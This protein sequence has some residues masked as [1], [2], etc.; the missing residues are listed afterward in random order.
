[1]NIHENRGARAL[2]EIIKTHYDENIQKKRHWVQYNAYYA[3]KAR[4]HCE[5]R[6]VHRVHSTFAKW[7]Q[8]GKKILRKRRRK[9]YKQH[10]FYTRALFDCRSSPSSTG[11]Y[12]GS[13]PDEARLRYRLP[14]PSSVYCIVIDDDSYMQ[15]RVTFFYCVHP[16]ERT[17]PSAGPAENKKS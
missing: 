12:A 9:I 7:R 6:H 8:N 11:G 15:W 3:M 16:W 10:A 2:N 17:R 13:I 14:R 4:T 5:T 1:M